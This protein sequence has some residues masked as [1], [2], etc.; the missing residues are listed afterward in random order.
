M[1][2]RS[3]SRQRAGCIFEINTLIHRVP[4]EQF[5]LLVDRTTDEAFLRETIQLAWQSQP[6]ESP[7]TLKSADTL[8]IFSWDSGRDSGASS[9][10]ALFRVLFG[11]TV[12]SA[13]A[14]PAKPA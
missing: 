11:T 6:P 8:Q 10:F 14:S 7:N 13:N 1:D 12:P 9:L 5:T 2:L 4:V 3:F